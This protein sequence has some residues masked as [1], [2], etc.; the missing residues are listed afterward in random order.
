MKLFK[1]GYNKFLKSLGINWER[2]LSKRLLP[3]SGIINLITKSVFIIE[4]KFQ[5][6]AGSVDEKLQT[7]DFK[8]KQ[9]K[10]LL[11]DTSY[12]VGFIYYL[13]EWFRKEEYNDV[14]QYILSVGCKYYFDTLPLSAIGLDKVSLNSIVS[15]K[16]IL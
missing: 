7:C 12:T 13:S 14:K 10:K 9:Y 5:N 2:K 1:R 6:S 15:D 4:K 8:L 16:K 11:E 3:D